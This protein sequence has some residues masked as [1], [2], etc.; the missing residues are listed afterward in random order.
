MELLKELFSITKVQALDEAKGK[1]KKDVRRPLALSMVPLTSFVAGNTVMS[2]NGDTMSEGKKSMTVKVDVQKPRGKH[3][4]DILRSRKGGRM[5]ADTDFDRNAMKRAT[6]AAL[7]EN[8]GE[9]HYFWFAA[10]EEVKNRGGGD[11]P[12]ATDRRNTGVVKAPD[13]EAAR[14]QAKRM[15]PRAYDIEVGTSTKEKYDRE[16]GRDE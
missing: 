16:I 9:E 12:E 11:G 3:V 14:A 2:G 15:Y 13:K 1:K 7:H 4:N 5:K 10:T 6:K 8:D